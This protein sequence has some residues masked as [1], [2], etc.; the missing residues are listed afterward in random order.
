MPSK[1]YLFFIIIV[2]KSNFAPLV[3]ITFSTKVTKQSSHFDKQRID[4]NLSKVQFLFRQLYI[5]VVIV[6]ERK[7]R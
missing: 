2:Y 1:I 7:K 4:M 6:S 5:Y 3:Y